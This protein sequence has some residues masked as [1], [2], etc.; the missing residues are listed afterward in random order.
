[1]LMIDVDHFK[2]YNDTYGHIA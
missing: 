1:M 2:S